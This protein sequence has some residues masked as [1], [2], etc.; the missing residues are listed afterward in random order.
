MNTYVCRLKKDYLFVS[1]R[2]LNLKRALNLKI[3][4]GRISF[5]FLRFTHAI[6]ISCLNDLLRKSFLFVNSRNQTH[7]IIYNGMEQHLKKQINKYN[8]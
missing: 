1:P 6:R 2:Y 4:K 8:K 3:K 5:F 7:L